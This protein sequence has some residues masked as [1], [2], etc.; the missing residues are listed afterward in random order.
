MCVRM[1]VLALSSLKRR[2]REQRGKARAERK[3]WSC[4]ICLSIEIREC[5]EKPKREIKIKK[6]SIHITGHLSQASVFPPTLGLLQTQIKYFSP[7]FPPKLANLLL[8]VGWWL[9]SKGQ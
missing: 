1:C 7:S 3:G 9:L 8:F 4:C 6:D 2:E 5:A